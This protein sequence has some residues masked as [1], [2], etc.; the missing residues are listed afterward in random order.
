MVQLRLIVVHHADALFMGAFLH[1][2]DEGRKENVG[3]KSSFFG[4]RK[5]WRSPNIRPYQKN[6]QAKNLS[7]FYFVNNILTVF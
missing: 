3:N 1:Y 2:A 5:L 6:R 4:T 7:I